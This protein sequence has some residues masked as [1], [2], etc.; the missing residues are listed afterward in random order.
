MMH[1][2]FDGKQLSLCHEKFKYWLTIYLWIH[3]V[4]GVKVNILEKAEITRKRVIFVY[5]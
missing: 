1:Y 4:D 5:S 3:N 2:Q